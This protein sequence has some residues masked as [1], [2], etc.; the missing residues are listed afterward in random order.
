M[1]VRRWRWTMTDAALRFVEEA[2]EHEQGVDAGAGGADYAAL[3]NRE[4][5]NA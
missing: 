1:L 4:T 2:L 3:A 5:R